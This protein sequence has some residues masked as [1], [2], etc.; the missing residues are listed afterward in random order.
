MGYGANN[1][2]VMNEGWGEGLRHNALIISELSSKKS[3]KEH[4]VIARGAGCITKL[5]DFCHIF[6]I[7]S[8]L[9]LNI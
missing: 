7:S 5:L 3:I 6:Q 2:R 4:F 8:G 9:F 1:Q